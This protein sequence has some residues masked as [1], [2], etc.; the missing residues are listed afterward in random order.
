MVTV[1]ADIDR[2]SLAVRDVGIGIFPDRADLN[3]NVAGITVR[4]RLGAAHGRIRC[5]DRA[6]AEPV[7]R[8]VDACDLHRP[9]RCGFGIGYLPRNDISARRLIAGVI[10]GNPDPL[11]EGRRDHDGEQKHGYCSIDPLAYSLIRHFDFFE[12]SLLIW[13]EFSLH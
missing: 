2:M 8:A 4:N 9:V 13:T 10:A 5:N 6:R 7:D 1:A 12:A 11:G 3:L